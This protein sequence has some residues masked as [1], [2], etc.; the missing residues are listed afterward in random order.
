MNISTSPVE[1]DKLDE[2]PNTFIPQINENIEHFQ[3]AK[4]YNTIRRQF[5]QQNQTLIW[6]IQIKQTKREF[7]AQ[8]ETGRICEYRDGRR[9]PNATYA[10][11]LIEG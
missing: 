9:R 5:P 7:V 2:S 10:R 1:T 8:T 11:G 4:I 6:H 3:L